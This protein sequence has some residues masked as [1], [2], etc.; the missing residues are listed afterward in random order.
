VVN[1]LKITHNKIHKLKIQ[2]EATKRTGTIQHCRWWV[3]FS[4]GATDRDAI[5]PRPT[6][7]ELAFSVRQEFVTVSVSF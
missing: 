6:V 2:F 3:I 7:P 5:E 1:S 4:V